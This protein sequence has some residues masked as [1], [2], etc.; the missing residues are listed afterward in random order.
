MLELTTRPCWA[1]F[2]QEAHARVYVMFQ[3]ST[4]RTLFF[5]VYGVEYTGVGITLETLQ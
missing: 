3:L 2:R 1:M 4:R 5:D